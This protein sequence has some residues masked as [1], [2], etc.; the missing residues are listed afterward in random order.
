VGAKRVGVVDSCVVGFCEVGFCEVGFCEV[1]FCEVGFCEVGFC[2]VDFCDR[3]CG[4]R[5]CDRVE[6]SCDTD[7]CDKDFSVVDFS[8]EGSCAEGYDH[9]KDSCVEG[10]AF[11]LAST[12]FSVTI[13][14]WEE[15]GVAKDFVP[16][17]FW[18]GTFHV[19]GGS[20][21]SGEEDF[22]FQPHEVG[23]GSFCDRLCLK[24]FPS[25]QRF[26][27]KPSFLQVLGRSCG[28]RLLRLPFYPQTQ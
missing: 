17:L 24:L 25:P 6:D 5:G 18:E 1:G 16:F 28:G 7:F 15:N 19:E 8:V 4:D 21:F 13:P 3:G 27:Q 10:C 2:E 14:V 23:C 22:F 12:P 20:G 11:A 26:A 9:G